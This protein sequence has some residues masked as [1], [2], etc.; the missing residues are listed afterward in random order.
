MS[1][2]GP[3]ITKPNGDY[4]SLPNCENLSFSVVLS[5][6]QDEAMYGLEIG[7][8]LIVSIEDG[9]VVAKKENTDQIVG[10]INWANIN[11]LIKCIEDGFQYCAK[12]ININD[13]YIKTHV[14][15]KE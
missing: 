2:N 5:S 4:D 8:N 7:I 3:G 13:G 1:G 10:S 14:M 15:I 9:V 6:P 12:I 11:H